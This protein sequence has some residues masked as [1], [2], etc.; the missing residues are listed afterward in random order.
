[1]RRP[2][3]RQQTGKN[4]NAE[5]DCGRENKHARIGR[6]F[7][8][9]RNAGEKRFHRIDAPDCEDQSSKT[10]KNSED[11]AF[12]RSCLMICQRPAPR[13]ARMLI[14]R[15]RESERASNKFA[16]LTHA[17]SRTQPAIAHNMNN[18]ERVLPTSAA[19]SGITFA[20]AFIFC[21]YC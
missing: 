15:F 18:A 20:P 14:S 10:A 8:H 11:R 21:G 13:A 9:P 16:T 12:N 1:M 3:R 4:S 19:S 17:T 5:T 2:P 6:D 7:V